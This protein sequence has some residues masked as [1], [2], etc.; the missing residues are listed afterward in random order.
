MCYSCFSIFFYSLN[1]DEHS[2]HG[3]SNYFY[4][5]LE[6]DICYIYVEAVLQSEIIFYVYVS[7]IV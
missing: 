3:S 2:L 1:F 5:S 4:E 6:M 7:L